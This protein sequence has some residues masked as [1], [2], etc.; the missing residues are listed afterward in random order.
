MRKIFFSLLTVLLLLSFTACSE[1]DN[2]TDPKIYGYLLEQF[3]ST[4]AVIQITDP[5]AEANTDF[6][7][8]YTYEIVASD[9]YSPRNSSNAGYDL[10]WDVLKAGYI[11]P[12]DNRR[13]WFDNPDMP[14]AFRVKDA[15]NLRLYRKVDIEDSLGTTYYVELGSL[16]VHQIENWDGELEDAIKLSDLLTPFAQYEGVTLYAYDDYAKEYTPEQIQDG[17]YFPQSEVSTFPTFN[18]SMQGG[19]KKFKKLAGIVVGGVAG[20]IDYDNAASSSTDLDI[21]LP[22]T[23]GGY[24]ATELIDY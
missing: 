2:T 22:E 14:G 10:D 8:L 17:Y 24:E 13:T 19:Q 7:D 16:P 3:V 12:D 5:S 21:T 23:F 15:T 6:R 18:D 20:S 1:D 4:D 11:V 9:G